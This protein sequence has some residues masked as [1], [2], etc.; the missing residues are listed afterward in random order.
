MN[1]L[2]IDHV[3]VAGGSGQTYSLLENYPE[4]FRMSEAVTQE[5]MQGDRTGRNGCIWGTEIRGRY[6]LPGKGEPD[7]IHQYK[8]KEDRRRG[9]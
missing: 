1:L 4:L 9:P 2:L 5:I 3:I 8:T 6:R 7:G